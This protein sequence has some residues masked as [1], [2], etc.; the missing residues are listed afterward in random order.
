MK[1]EKIS[2]EIIKKYIRMEILLK[3]NFIHCVADRLKPR[4]S[5]TG[6][7]RTFVRQSTRKPV[8]PKLTPESFFKLVLSVS[9][10]F[11]KTG[12]STKVR[13]CATKKFLAIKSRLWSFPYIVNR[14]HIVLLLQ[15]AMSICRATN[16]Y[17]AVAI[18]TELKVKMTYLTSLLWLLTRLT[19]LIHTSF[20]PSKWNLNPK[21]SFSA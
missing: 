13:S 15:T 10:S 14:F 7:K 4:T 9:P 5:W 20:L 2:S 12:V 1:I 17:I 8:W 11:Q 3:N 19:W 16:K 6:N 18:N 21:I